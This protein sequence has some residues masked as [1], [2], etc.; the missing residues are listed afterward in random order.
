MIRTRIEETCTDAEQFSI[1]VNMVSRYS[2]ASS[3]EIGNLDKLGELM[4]YE[5][6][7]MY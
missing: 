4:N 3:G 6:H 5:I 2:T 7:H 1:S